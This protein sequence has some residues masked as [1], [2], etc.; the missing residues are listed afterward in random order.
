MDGS[1]LP[2]VEELE[3]SEIVNQE[4]PRKII[5]V[6]IEIIVSNKDS[7]DKIK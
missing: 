7:Y 5:Y 1:S 6:K 4:I 3:N 2:F